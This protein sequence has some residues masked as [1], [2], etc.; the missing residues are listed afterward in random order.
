M[1]T[2]ALPYIF[3]KKTGDEMN[4]LLAAGGRS[5]SYSNVVPEPY[6][7]GETAEDIP[8]ALNTSSYPA[9][10]EN[11]LVLPERLVV[12]S[13]N[14]DGL[15]PEIVKHIAR[16][17]F[18]Y[19]RLR[20]L[21]KAGCELAERSQLIQQRYHDLDLAKLSAGKGSG[22]LSHV[23]EYYE[24]MISPKLKIKVK[25]LSK[26]S[27]LF[28]QCMA[29][30]AKN[31]H[32]KAVHLDLNDNQVGLDNQALVTT[33][34]ALSTLPTLT[35]LDIMKNFLGPKG[36][37][38]VSK[39][40]NITALDIYD[41]GIGV[42]GAKFISQMSQLKKLNIAGNKIG[43]QGCQHLL[44]LLQ[45]KELN[46]NCDDLTPEEEEKFVAK[47]PAHMYFEVCY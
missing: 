22:S 45:L 12:P 33:L 28:A 4:G 26:H 14:L 44:G 43:R 38:F 34:Q 9:P 7:E 17:D 2:Y 3:F 6:K 46:I 39:M 23:C 15:L 30:L 18:C 47:L 8:P 36:A 25:E 10:D 37:E 16:Y 27:L 5:L 31:S 20:L 13:T 40:R 42:A 11:M 19:R 21:S 29:S 1:T 35:G 41:N 24:K 32:V